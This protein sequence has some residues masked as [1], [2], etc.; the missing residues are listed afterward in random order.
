MDLY[1]AD[2]SEIPL[3]PDEVRIR[4]LRAEPWADGQRVR[5]YLETDPFQKRPSA[6]LTITDA[7]GQEVA[8]A[9]VIESMDRKM[10]MTL[11][12]RSSQPL[13]PYRLHAVLYYATF[14]QPE[15]GEL[16][17]FDG[18]PEHQIVDSHEIVFMGSS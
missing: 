12:L 1:L 8:S 13:G 4:E 15:V 17:L 6:E 18:P 5:V 2:P 14:T 16:D 10:E 9:S 3:P 11:H 7:N